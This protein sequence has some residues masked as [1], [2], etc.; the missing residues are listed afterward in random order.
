M[1][2]SPLSVNYLCCLD[3]LHDCFLDTIN[4]VLHI[5]IAYVWTCRETETN[6]EEGF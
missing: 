1:T 4:N 5:L 6:L 3:L 2:V